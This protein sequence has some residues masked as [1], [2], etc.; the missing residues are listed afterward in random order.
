MALA[1]INLLTG[2]PV[3]NPFGFMSD[4]LFEGIV[5]TPTTSDI[6]VSQTNGSHIVFHGTF[7][8]VGSD[9]TAGTVTGFDVFA[10]STNVMKGSGFSIP[11]ESFFDALQNF[12]VDSGPYFDIFDNIPIKLLGSSLGDATGGSLVDDVM[13]GK[14]GSD[15]LFGSRGDDFINGGKGD[16]LLSGEAGFDVLKGG[17]GRD[18]FDFFVDAVELPVGTDKIKDFTPGED[19]IGLTLAGAS[20]PPPGYL[21]D[22]YFHKGT[23][24]T[25]AEQRVIYDK[26]SGE[27]SIDRD[28]NGPEAQFVL[29]KVKAGTSLHADD[30]FFGSST[31]TVSDR[32]AKQDIEPVGRTFGGTTIYRYRYKAGGPFHFGVMAQDVERT[33]PE[34]VTIGPAGLKMVN[35]AKVK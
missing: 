17:T 5:Q 30:F 24:A 12:Q 16:D 25:D 14:A 32:R 31:M 22:Q 20:S 35:Y 15:R 1:Q 33:N 34:A 21:G 28:G 19:V 2:S 18:T 7:T 29:A 13:L 23:A 26:K 3:A 4:A 10:G 6:V 8:L 27:I 9:V 11:A